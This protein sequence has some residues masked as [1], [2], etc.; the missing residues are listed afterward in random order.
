M[1]CYHNKLIQIL[2]LFFYFLNPTKFSLSFFP[3]Y[4]DNCQ[5]CALP[6]EF[7]TSV[8]FLCFFCSAFILFLQIVE[9]LGALERHFRL[10]RGWIRGWLTLFQS[11]NEAV[12]V[13]VRRSRFQRLALEILDFNLQILSVFSSWRHV[14]VPWSLSV[15]VVV[16]VERREEITPYCQ[17]VVLLRVKRFV[18]VQG[19]RV[20]SIDDTSLVV[21]WLHL[22]EVI[23]HS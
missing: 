19:R 9:M 14:V 22:F 18:L 1:F 12:R 8:F 7:L 21:W 23:V 11:S 10:Q 2:S 4:F 3:I 17:F 15:V 6:L 13:G 20:L 5:L 16:L